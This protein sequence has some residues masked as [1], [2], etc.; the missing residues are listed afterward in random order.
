VEEFLMNS[1]TFDQRITATP[2]TTLIQDVMT[3]RVIS[4]TESAGT[5]TS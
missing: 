1:Q 4:V 5:R 3:T 2:A